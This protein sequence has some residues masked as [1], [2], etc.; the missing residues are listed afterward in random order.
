MTTSAAS[1]LAMPVPIG[2][3]PRM[4]Q[5]TLAYLRRAIEKMKALQSVERVMSNVERVMLNRLPDKFDL[6]S[7]VTAIDAL[8]VA[9]REG[10]EDKVREAVFAVSQDLEAA[11]QLLVTRDATI[12]PYHLRRFYEEETTSLDLNSLAALTSFYRALPHSESNRGKYDFVVTRLF[13]HAEPGRSVRYRHLRISREQL[14]KRL[15]EMCLAWGEVVAP[16][17]AEAVNVSKSI[18]LFDHFITE[19]K[20]IKKFDE[21][22]HRAFLQRIRDFKA[23]IGALLYLPEVTAASVES[24]VVVTNCFLTLLET[25]SEAIQAAPGVMHSLAGA[26]GDTYSNEPSE[27]AAI[28]HELEVSVQPSEAAQERVARLTHLLPHSKTPDATPKLRAATQPQRAS[29]PD[30][31]A[32]GSPESDFAAHPDATSNQNEELHP[33]IIALEN[34]PLLTAYSNASA[35]ARK[36]DLHSFLAPLPN[37][38]HKA[39][40]GESKSRRAAL[41]LIFAADNLVVTE[42]APEQTPGANIEARSEVLF[43]QLEQVSDEVR[44]QIKLAQKHEQHTNYEV[45]LHVY[46]QIMTARLR[47][48]SALVRRHGS[49]HS[50]TNNS[51]EAIAEAPAKAA[52]ASANS[53]PPPSSARISLRQWL[54]GT[55]VALLLVAV[56]L[57]F[58]LSKKP[59]AKDDADVARLDRNQ[60]PHGAFFTGAKIHQ[61]LM[62][63]Q[64]TPKWLELTAQ[65]KKDKIAELFS[66]GQEHGVQRVLL[67]DPKGTTIGFMTKEEVFL[68]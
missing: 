63:C 45:L 31:L 40:Q 14:A 41:A 67:I 27:V 13:S 21:L 32:I 43:D 22:V 59:E 33:F 58:G 7:V 66:F 28:L 17:P 46:N 38:D 44:D 61:E 39:S 64:V 24:N 3:P 23:R 68:Q 15:T 51:S 20:A 8:N 65:E 49:E 16:D 55:T 50:N 34:Q 57:N 5:R 30:T 42:L 48:Q 62:L 12:M 53:E 6:G 26:F 37:G 36:L 56:F 19:V 47:L 4:A 18:D 11:L 9:L 2:L 25:E 1:P 29:E 54:V 35:E 10:D 52:P 60:M